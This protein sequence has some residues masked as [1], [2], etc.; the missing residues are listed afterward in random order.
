MC[1]VYASFEAE[2]KMFKQDVVLTLKGHP[3]A[4]TK[5]VDQ[6]TRE[7]ERKSINKAQNAT[8]G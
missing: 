5:P 1:L 3:R 8:K 2:K 6:T 7:K 4:D